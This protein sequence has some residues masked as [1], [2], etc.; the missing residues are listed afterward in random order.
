MAKFFDTINSKKLFEL[1]RELHY[2]MRQLLLSMVLHQAQRRL[3]LW[4]ALGEA[5]VNLGRSILAGCKRPTQLARVYTIKMVNELIASHPSTTLYTYV[6]YISNLIKAK[7]KGH[8][9]EN[10]VKCAR[11]FAEHASDLLLNISDKTTVVLNNGATKTFAGMMSREGIPMKAAADG[12]D[13]GADTSSASR[14]TTKTQRARIV[15]TR[16][17][18]KRPAFLPN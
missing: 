9:F 11:G 6:A 15:Q 16:S 4:A 3:Q 10:V 18:A 12:N 5:I 8:L 2:P 1:A 13:I 7:T 14:S 17:R